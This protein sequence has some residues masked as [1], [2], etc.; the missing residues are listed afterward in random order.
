MTRTFK[1]LFV[2]NLKPQRTFFQHLQTKQPSYSVAS[3]PDK[4][5]NDQ[6]IWERL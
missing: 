3:A 2:A 4:E 6:A 5:N 1:I